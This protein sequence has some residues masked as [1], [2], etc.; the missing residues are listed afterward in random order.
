MKNLL[1]N[2]FFSFFVIFIVYAIALL[3]G[4]YLYQRLQ[5]PFWMA[6]L[7]CDV[8]STFLVFIFSLAFSNASV[9]D[10]YWSVQPLV[11]VWLYGLTKGLD[12]FGI[13]LTVVISFWA[14]R[15]TANWAYTF[16]NLLHQDWRYTML[17]EKTKKFYPFVNFFGIHLVPTLI[18]YACT[19]PAVFVIEKYIEIKAG[20]FVFLAISLLAVCLQGISDWQMH[21]FRK[22]EDSQKG[23]FIRLGFW[24]YSRHP[25]YLGEILMWWGIALAVFFADFSYWYLLGG[26][27]FNTLL[28]VFISIPMAENHQRQR[29]EGFDEYKLETRMLFPIKKVNKGKK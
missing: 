10:P 26:A 23:N 6:L 20:S 3:E 12:I 4:V 22:S 9:Y 14:L 17:K 1:E 8:V 25:N 16:K 13:L 28:F 15:L 24:K 7:V 19:L 2:R 29:K 5:M 11:I 21:R 27:F 18:V